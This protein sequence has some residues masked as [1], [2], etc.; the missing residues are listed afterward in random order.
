MFWPC[1]RGMLEYL[2]IILGGMDGGVPKVTLILHRVSMS[3]F[4]YQFK[5]KILQ[6]PTVRS[7]TSVTE[8]C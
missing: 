8:W 7:N 5:R 3:P 4:A 1:R 6:D 2:F